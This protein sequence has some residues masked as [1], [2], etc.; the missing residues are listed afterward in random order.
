M[1][2]NDHFST[3]AQAY[4]D[5]RPDYPPELYEFIVSQVNGYALCWDVATGNGR[6]LWPSR[7]TLT[8]LWQQ[9]RQ[10]HSCK[11]PLPGPTLITGV[12]QLKAAAWRIS[13]LI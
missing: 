8:G 3:Q 12:S 1:A 6:P 9:M 2:F 4:V 10:W 13:L 11:S 7:N 5:S